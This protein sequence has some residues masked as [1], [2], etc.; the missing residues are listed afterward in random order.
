MH[1]LNPG[2]VQLTRHDGQ[3]WWVHMQPRR[4]SSG[5]ASAQRQRHL[6]H[7]LPSCAALML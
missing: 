7:W 5:M 3:D 1:S 4:A 6:V 2:M